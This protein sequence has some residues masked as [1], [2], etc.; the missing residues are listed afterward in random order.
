MRAPEPKL[1]QYGPAFDWL[2]QKGVSSARL[3]AVFGTTPANARV[4]A[5]RARHGLNPEP[6]S[7]TGLDM[8]PTVELAEGLGV[9]SGPDEIVDTP[10]RLRKLDR[11]RDEIDQTV[12][13]YASRYDFLAGSRALRRLLP[14]IGNPQDARR[15]ALAALLH[16]HIAW[17][18]VH[19]GQCVTASREARMAQDLWRIAWHESDSK[20]FAAGFVEAALIE[21]NSWLLARNPR[22]ALTVLDLAGQAAASI[23]APTGSEHFRQRGAA[24]FQLREDERA[25]S[26]FARA[27]EAMERLGEARIPAQLF[28]TGPR[29]TNLL[30]S[31]K[32]DKA[33]ELVVTARE[34]FGTESLEASMALHWATACGLTIGS[35]SVIRQ[36]QVLLE[37]AAIPAAQFGHQSTIRKLLAITP[38]LGLDDRLRSAWVRRALYENA[39]RAR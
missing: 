19:A 32:W 39:F 37:T 21:S 1:S 5:F 15:I 2:L 10:I 20:E 35:A 24:L 23:G 4:I 34:A 6:A 22:K 33:Q 18:L 30:G 14:Q 8:P 11:L 17:F 7:N 36:A 31:P 27:T 16:Q 28:M 3:A 26:H 12:A 25:T 38:E 13:R 9:R 29:Q